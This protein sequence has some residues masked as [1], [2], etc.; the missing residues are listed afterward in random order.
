[1]Q[2]RTKNPSGPLPMIAIIGADGSGK[3][4][5]IK[6]LV[7]HF[8][9]EQVRD[10]FVLKRTKRKQSKTEGR[11]IQNYAKA[12]RS[13][14]VCVPK[15]ILKALFWSIRYRFKIVPLLEKGV[16]VIADHFNFLIMALDPLKCR[17]GGPA[18]LLWKVLQWVPQPDVYILLD[19]DVSIL[20]K[21]KQ[22]APSEDVKRLIERH[23][24]FMAK[25]NHNGYSVDASLPLEQ[26]TANVS[27]LITQVIGSG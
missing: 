12:P 15:L 14:F 10:I 5:V 24:D 6:N 3:S 19:A 23:R 26:V 20:Y 17:Y 4:A 7:K 13:L 2:S 11:D 27:Q 22:E 18:W 25:Q 16:L 1:M 9:H 21:R 8:S